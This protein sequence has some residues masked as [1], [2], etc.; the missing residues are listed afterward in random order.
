MLAR[1]YPELEGAVYCAKRMSLR[2][3]WRQFWF[4]VQIRQM[5]ARARQKQINI[6]LAESRAKGFDEGRL[7]GHTEGLAV[8]HAEGLSLGHA[9]G[10]LE[11]HAEGF[12]IGHA[13]G[14]SEGIAVGYNQGHDKGHAKG[15]DEGIYAIAKKL[16]DRGRPLSE[17]VEDTGLS[18]E[19]VEKL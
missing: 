2:K 18:A 13:E 9:K 17:I 1:D 10:R 6:D 4:E 12:A 16:K 8:G 11:G 19:A 15:F 7:E 14:R 5:D 3:F